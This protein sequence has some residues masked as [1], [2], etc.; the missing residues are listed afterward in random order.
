MLFGVELICVFIR[1][2]YFVWF[3]CVLILGS[4]CYGV[5]CVMLVFCCVLLV[6]CY[7]LFAVC[8]L[9]FVVC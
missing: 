9:L 6:D 3:A 7:L 8:C 2:V 4:S 1:C 5:C